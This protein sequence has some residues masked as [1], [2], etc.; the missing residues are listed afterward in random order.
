[1]A[2]SKTREEKAVS[3]GYKPNGNHDVQGYVGTVLTQGA[4]ITLDQVV[5]NALVEMALSKA[6]MVPMMESN[7]SEVHVVPQ[8]NQIVEVATGLTVTLEE[9]V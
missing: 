5:V 2:F 3:L 8:H 9:D 4:N 1:M 7:T 6:Q